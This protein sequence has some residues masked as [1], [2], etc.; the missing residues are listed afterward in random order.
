M[1]ELLEILKYTIPSIVVLITAYLILKR[2]IDFN[3]ENLTWLKDYFEKKDQNEKGDKSAEKE[4]VIPL[5]LQ[6]YERL[7]LFLERINPPNLV[8][9]EMDQRLT[10]AQFQRKLLNAV[11]NEFEHNITQ[12]IYLSDEVWNLVK[13]A[14]EEVMSL[15]NISAKKVKPDDP[16]LKLAETILSNS[17]EEEKNPVETAISAIK[18]EM[19][20][21]FS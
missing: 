8:V 4:A 17:F 3:N 13:N 10:A 2:F 16:A 12:Q 21:N 18:S 14:K 6:A 15:I 11:R 1:T 9:R 19:K 5:K 7:V 20:K